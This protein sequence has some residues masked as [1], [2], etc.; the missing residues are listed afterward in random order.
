MAFHAGSTVNTKYT[1]H[2]G[3]TELVRIDASG[4]VGIGTNVATPQYDKTLHIEGAN[5]TVRLET[6]YS[7]GWAYN[8]YVSPETTW[9][10]GINNLDQFLHFK[11]HLLVLEQ[12]I[13][14]LILM[15][16]V[17]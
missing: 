3:T 5:P 15:F 1:F 8:Q 13:H 16:L 7:A 14:I 10:V 9:S 11:T 4:N 2:S 17:L 6:N 12:L